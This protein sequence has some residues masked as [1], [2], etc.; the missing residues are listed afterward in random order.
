MVTNRHGLKQELDRFSKNIICADS[1]VAS[2]LAALRAG[3]AL[4]RDKERRLANYRNS[5]FSRDWS[6]SFRDVVAALSRQPCS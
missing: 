2:L 5:T 1:D 4:A 3:A 6:A